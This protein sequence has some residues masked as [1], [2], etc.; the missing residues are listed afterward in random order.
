MLRVRHG[1]RSQ[2]PSRQQQG[3]AAEA[4]PGAPGAARG[5]QDPRAGRCGSPLPAPRTPRDPGTPA[6]ASRVLGSAPR[7]S[8][9]GGARPECPLSPPRR[10]QQLRKDPAGISVCFPRGRGKP[11]GGKLKIKQ[12]KTT[13][14]NAPGLQGKRDGRGGAVGA[15]ARRVCVG[16]G[17]RGCER[18][19]ARVSAPRA[20]A[21][22]ISPG[23]RG[24]FG[25]GLEMLRLRLLPPR[26]AGSNI[27]WGRIKNY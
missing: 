22:T 18:A 8:R 17:V 3:R 21:L 5:A 10:T 7:K 23:E 16:P 1:A 11:S 24:H 26:H 27:S 14:K 15:G 6:A 19:C 25:V 9:D 12:K 2:L 20:G 13:T 4:R